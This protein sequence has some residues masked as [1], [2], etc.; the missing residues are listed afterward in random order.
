MY[1]IKEKLLALP[2][3]FI[4]NNFL[5][6]YCELILANRLTVKQK[7]ITQKHHIVPRFYFKHNKLAIDNSSDNL[8]NLSHSDHLLA[9]YYLANCVMDFYQ[10]VA[11]YAL[12]YM[13][14]K[15]IK[16][17]E[18]DIEA[19]DLHNYQ[20]LRED[21][22]QKQGDRKRGSTPWNKGVDL[23]QVASCRDWIERNRQRMLGSKMSDETKLKKSKSMLGKYAGTF[24]INNGEQTIR[25]NPEDLPY[26]ENLGWTRGA[27]QNHT[28]TTYG[29]VTINKGDEER[30]IALD[31]LDEYIQEGWVRGRSKKSKISIKNSGLKGKIPWNKGKAASEEAKQ[32]MRENHADFKGSKLM[33][34]GC[35]RKKIMK[36]KI[37][38][39]LNDGWEFVRK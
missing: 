34:N 37:Q 31:Y 16:T 24:L 39:Y 26:Y 33:T 18:F 7:F 32:H 23:N 19:L 29:T 2:N 30:R 11:S 25:I 38:E 5:D 35:I 10:Y 12:F 20:Q 17:D 27:I 14:N 9:H 36:D 21:L 6:K 4:D 3:T 8:V 22:L 13:Y 1:I 15:A 28:K